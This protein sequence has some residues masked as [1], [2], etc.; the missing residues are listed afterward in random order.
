ML[1]TQGVLKIVDNTGVKQV[2]IV[3]RSGKCAKVGDTVTCV[4]Q[5]VRA[6]SKL[7]KKSLASVQ[8]LGSCFGHKYS[9]GALV[10]SIVSNTG[11]LVSKSG[12]PLGTRISMPFSRQYFRRM[13]FMKILTIA[14]FSIL[15]FNGPHLSKT[16]ESS[17]SGKTESL[18]S[19]I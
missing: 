7:P 18:R 19:F 11:V 3:I 15:F 17:L 9:D 4:I 1:I 5:R 10:R 6:S 2:Y 16:L 13:G 12:D 14:P 8:I